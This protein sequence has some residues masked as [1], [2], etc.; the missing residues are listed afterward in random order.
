MRFTF[1]VL[2]FALSTTVLGQRAN[3]TSAYNY[4]KYGEL[5]KA[6]QAIDEAAE[7]GS[8]SDWWKTWFFRGNIYMSIARSQEEKF[9]NLSENPVKEA[10]ESYKK[11]Y[12]ME[13]NRKMD[14]N[15]LDRRFK[16]IY[17]TA[18]NTGIEAY[19]AKDY[20]K[21][22]E[23]F[24]IC[25]GV[26]AHFDKVDTL[27]M[28]NVALTSDLSGDIDKA[29]EYYKKCIEY[30]YKGAQTANDL[31]NMYLRAEKTDKAK[32]AV[33]EMRKIYPN[34]QGLLTTELNFYLSEGNFDEALTNLDLAIK[35]DPDNSIFYY[36]RGTI[37]NEKGEVEKAKTDYLS[38][39]EK[40]SSNF[41]A[42]Y[43]LGALYYNQG[44]D[45]I[46]SCNDIPVSENAKYEKCKKEATVYFEKAL[47]HLEAAY[48][49]N[50][51][52]QNTIVS[53]KQCYSRTGQTEKYQQLGK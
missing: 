46:N 13:R 7:D 35:N 41:D 49:I 15:D 30:D 44:A 22:R 31:V 24:L 29:A 33:K 9:Q 40:D 36:A 28:Y 16:N 26:N 23:Y 38:A 52:D 4:E 53:L 32:E 21:A 8:T 11:L 3:V 5:D 20:L 37:Y 10:Y 50:P 19:N 18:F 27:S 2:L 39:I 17:P 47:P 43:N 1:F 12:E 42:L 34:D 6:K 25:E 48:A 45:K 14:Y 51:E